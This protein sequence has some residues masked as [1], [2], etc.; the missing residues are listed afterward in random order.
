M[1][2]SPVGTQL[3]HRMRTY[4]ALINCTTIDWYHPWTSQ[5][6]HQVASHLLKPHSVINDKSYTVNG[7]LIQIL[8]FIHDFFHKS[9]AKVQDEQRRKIFITPTLF[10][11][12]LEHLN[13]FI[14]RFEEE[15]AV[16]IK[17]YS[18]GVKKITA[19]EKEIAKMK[20]ELSELQERLE[21]SRIENEKILKDLS[22]KQLEA[23]AEK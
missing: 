11:Q 14:R 9:T 1:S 4:P 21:L 8:V 15:I 7:G 22:V 6:Y 10:L 17:K 18:N 16:Q 3:R 23:D 12:C 2:M 13:A 20:D 5:A 19:T